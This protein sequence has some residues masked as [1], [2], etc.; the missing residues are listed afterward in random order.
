VYIAPRV[1]SILD[2]FFARVGV[3][4]VIVAMTEVMGAKMISTE[5]AGAGRL[6]SDIA[7]VVL[8]GYLGEK[9][10]FPCAGA[11]TVVGS[12]AGPGDAIINRYSYNL[13]YLALATRTLQAILIIIPLVSA[14]VAKDDLA[15]F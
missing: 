13:A 7:R 6:G 3:A 11:R 4:V 12:K 8:W 5:N 14:V 15:A 9:S 2:I 10:A 1:Q